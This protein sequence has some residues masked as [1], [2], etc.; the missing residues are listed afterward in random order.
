L[1][2]GAYAGIGVGVAAFVVFTVSFIIAWKKR[3]GPFRVKYPKQ[4]QE[5][6]E[7]VEISGDTKSFVEIS[8]KERFEVPA[9]ERFEVPA[10]EARQEVADS[11][12]H[13][14]ELEG[15]NTVYELAASKDT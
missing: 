12:A 4:E 2:S 13:R 14:L 5:W 15:N 10:V 9:R 3:W 7:R 6:I 8:A 11:Q 1:S